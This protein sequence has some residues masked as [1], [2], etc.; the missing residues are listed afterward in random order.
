MQKKLTFSRLLIGLTPLSLVFWNT[1]SMESAYED[2][3]RQMCR[4]YEEHRCRGSGLL[5]QIYILG[6]IPEPI[7]YKE[8]MEAL[9]ISYDFRNVSVARE[10][11][12]IFQE[13]LNYFQTH[14]RVRP[15]RPGPLD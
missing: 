6:Q 13:M 15:M 8:V 1:S 14:L 7:D 2:L 4:H 3:F 11:R 5:R 10:N 12:N 9:W